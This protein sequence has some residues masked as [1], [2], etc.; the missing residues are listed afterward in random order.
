M[1]EQTKKK[2]HLQANIPAE[3]GERLLNYK[4]VIGMPVSEQVR[5]ALEAFL[6]ERNY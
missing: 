5:R 1:T 2:Y 3:L 6:K 4:H